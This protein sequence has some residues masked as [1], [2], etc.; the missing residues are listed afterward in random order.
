MPFT[1]ITFN[2]GAAPGIDGP[3]MNFIETQFLEASLSFE[4][5]LFSP[6]VLTGLVATRDG[7]TL[8]QLD[9]TAGVA[10]LKQS[11]DNTL[12]RQAP[13]AT[14]FST[15]G[16]PSTTMYLDLNPDGTWSWG[17]AHSAQANYLAVAQVVTDSSANINTVTDER[18]TVVNFLA[19]LIGHL[20]MPSTTQIGGVNPA[21]QGSHSAGQ[22]IISYGTG[23]PS[24]LAA[25]EIFI[26]LS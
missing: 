9:L 24:S 2:T 6:F 8:S 13:T 15:T 14:N 19:A 16:H 11:A 26:Q 22:P 20:N 21:L 7:T 5:D 10:F 3:T 4:Q 1:P 18:I 23:T 17:T 12:R 25:N